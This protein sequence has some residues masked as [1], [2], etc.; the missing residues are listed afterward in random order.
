MLLIQGWQ[1]NAD[2]NI[3]FIMKSVTQWNVC[4]LKL[5]PALVWYLYGNILFTHL[6]SVLLVLVAAWLLGR[7]MFDSNSPLSVKRTGPWSF[8]LTAPMPWLELLTHYLLW[9]TTGVVVWTVPLSDRGGKSKIWRKR[10]LY[11]LLGHCSILM[12]ISISVRRRWRML[13]VVVPS[14]VQIRRIHHLLMIIC[15][16]KTGTGLIPGVMVKAGARR[17]LR[18]IAAYWRGV[19]DCRLVLYRGI[20]EQLLT[21]RAV[22]RS[23]RVFRV[24][25]LRAS[26]IGIMYH[27]GRGLW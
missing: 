25:V 9:E 10:P 5:F 14:R 22:I 3:L 7:H 13:G 15:F 11:S 27:R 24:A 6:F 21:R 23:K 2:V 8:E 17:D 18:S 19:W 16:M 1:D 4:K 20:T 12:P 26:M